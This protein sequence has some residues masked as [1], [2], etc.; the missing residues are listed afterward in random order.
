ME[1]FN[2]LKTSPHISLALGFFDGIH[3]G[4]QVVIKNAIN[5]AKKEGTKSAI[6]MFREHPMKFITGAK[7][8][9]ILYIEDKLSYLEKIGVDEVYLMDFPSYENLSAEEYIKDV[10]IKSCITAISI[11]YKKH[12]L[13]INS[14]TSLVKYFSLTTL[15]SIPDNKSSKSIIF[16]KDISPLFLFIIASLL[17]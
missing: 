6:L 15:V 4:H 13:L 5:I 9:N 2:E 17:K 10:L 1:V 11:L 16:L 8:K 12:K 14:F 3:E 7:T